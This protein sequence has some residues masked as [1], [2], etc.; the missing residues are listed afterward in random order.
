MACMG[1]GAPPAASRRGGGGRRLRG[2]EASWHWGRSCGSD[3]RV[4]GCQRWPA[5]GEALMVEEA[6]DGEPTVLAQTRGRC[7]R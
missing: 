4:G 1:G 5:V 6:A 2:Q 3:R 7:A